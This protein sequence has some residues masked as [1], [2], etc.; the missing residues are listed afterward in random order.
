MLSIISGRIILLIL[1]P[2]R[3]A[4]FYVYFMPIKFLDPKGHNY[5]E[6][7]SSHSGFNKTYFQYSSD[8]KILQAKLGY[9]E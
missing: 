1:L 3:T 4:V 2:R 7:I 5:M 6:T 9:S 8:I